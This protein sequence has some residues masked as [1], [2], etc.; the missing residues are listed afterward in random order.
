[1]TNRKEV[2]KSLYLFLLLIYTE[3]Y[4]VPS[5]SIEFVEISTFN[6]EFSF[7][8][9][10]A[11]QSI[12]LHA[13]YLLNTST[14]HTETVKIVSCHLMLAAIVHNSTFPFIHLTLYQCLYY[15]INQLF[16]LRLSFIC[17]SLTKVYRLTCSLYFIT[18]YL[19]GYGKNWCI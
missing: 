9:W 10:F 12:K 14:F 7:L 16:N 2:K 11:T 19:T 6:S 4:L 5:I 17:F 18:N 3:K 15:R 13:L 1:M 8:N